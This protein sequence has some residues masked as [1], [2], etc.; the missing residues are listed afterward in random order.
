[1][2]TKSGFS[3]CWLRAEAQITRDSGSTYFFGKLI[4]S[5]VPATTTSSVLYSQAPATF[6]ATTYRVAEP[7]GPERGICRSACP[8]GPLT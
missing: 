2:T 7:F 4:R 3:Q 6:S 5:P 8:E 1:M